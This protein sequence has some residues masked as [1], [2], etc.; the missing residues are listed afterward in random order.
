MAFASSSAL[1]LADDAATL[2][3]TELRQRGQVE[4]RLGDIPAQPGRYHRLGQVLL[5]LLINAAQ[6]IPSGNPS[7]HRVVVESALRAV[8][9]RRSTLAN[10]TEVPAESIQETII[11]RSSPGS[12]TTPF[13][14]SIRS[15]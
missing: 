6:A 8:E 4:L 5:N 10:A 1:S 13:L 3:D 14:W 2:V 12:S 9:G 15:P 11:G 7:H